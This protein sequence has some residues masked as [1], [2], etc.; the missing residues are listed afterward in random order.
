MKPFGTDRIRPLNLGRG[1]RR[2]VAM[3]AP[4]AAALAFAAP[5]AQAGTANGGLPGAG[6]I[7]S[8]T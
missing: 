6:P 1:R 4:G 2:L 3:L 5:A 7:R 8:P